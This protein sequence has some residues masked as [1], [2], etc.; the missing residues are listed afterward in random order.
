MIMPERGK[1][2]RAEVFEPHKPD[3]GGH[4]RPT[5]G[6]G[7]SVPLCGHAVSGMN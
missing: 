3:E 7:M 5:S 6:S 4:A 2:G 1:H